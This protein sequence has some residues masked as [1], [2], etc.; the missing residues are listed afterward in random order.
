[1]TL[2]VFERCFPALLAVFVL[3]VSLYHFTTSPG[4]WF[5]EGIIAQVSNNI[6]LRGIYG[7][8]TAPDVFYTEN[9]WITTGYTLV[10]PVALFLKIFGVSVWA[11][12]IAPFLYLIGFVIVSYFFVKAMYGFRMAAFASLLVATFNPL[13]GNGKAVLGEIPG[14][15]WLVLGGLFFLYFEKSK[16][17][18]FL[19]AA[20]LAW[21]MC[22]STK[23]YYA[24]FIPSAVFLALYL[25]FWQKSISYRTFFLSAGTFA[26]PVILWLFFALGLSATGDSVRILLYFLNSYGAAS[27]EP[28]RNLFRFVSESTPAHFTILS[29]TIIAAW[30]IQRRREA[31]SPLFYAF[32]IFIALSFLWYLKTPGWYRY[33]FSVHVLVLLLFPAAADAVASRIAVWARMPNAGRALGITAVGALI[34]FQAGFLLF[35]Y[36][37]FYGADA[38]AVGDYLKAVLPPSASVFVVSKPELAFLIDGANIYQYIYINPNLAI[39]ENRLVTMPVD[40]IVGGI[41]GDPF[42]EEN[43]FVIGMQYE[44]LRTFGH[45]AVYKNRMLE[46]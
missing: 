28:L 1:M 39:G 25:L 18:P 5:D 15:F 22:V 43:R 45:Y 38:L 37:D 29:V 10:F 36:D 41:S 27:F 42:I 23:P 19:F 7:I 12:R 26:A 33:F 2:R 40:F 11:A 31:S 32:F 35:H 20:A 30:L 17:K 46:L 34:L 16:K 8:Q 24:L 6:A 9:F 44:R 14:L 3:S 21:G 13:Y 4:F